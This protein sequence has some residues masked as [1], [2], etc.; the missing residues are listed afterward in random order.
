MANR[1]R[2]L[3]TPHAIGVAFAC[4]KNGMRRQFS[5]IWIGVGSSTREAKTNRN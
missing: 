1:F 5:V 3:Q 2:N 4:G